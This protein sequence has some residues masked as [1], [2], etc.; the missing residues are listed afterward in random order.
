MSAVALLV[1]AAC[2]RGP[3]AS[4]DLIREFA[5]AD[6][7][8]A[9]DAM[10]VDVA[11]ANGDARTAVIIRATARVAWRLQFPNRIRLRTAV[12]LVPDAA[13]ALGPGVNARVGIS[14]GRLYE[15]LR[16]V[17][18]E[19][20]GGTPPAWMP[21]DIDLAGY[22]GRQWSVFYRPSRITWD[23]ILAADGAP[24]GTIAWAQPVVE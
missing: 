4:I 15:T 1:G 7:R 21:I 16:Q 6:H 13:G 22:S 18:L 5:R 3:T 19:A 11:S 20:G 10:R 24:G 12:A 23:F 8:G 17:K 9:A 2:A 14:D